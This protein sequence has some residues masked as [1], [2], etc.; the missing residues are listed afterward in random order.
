MTTFFKSIE[1]SELGR[2]R[3]A[4]RSKTLTRHVRGRK[5]AELSELSVERKHL[6]EK[7]E[8]LFESFLVMKK[9]I[10]SSKYM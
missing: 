10:N 3:S 6:F 7:A 2:K 8:K 4:R 1:I 5:L 9:P